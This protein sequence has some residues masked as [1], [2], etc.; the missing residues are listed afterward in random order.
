MKEIVWAVL[1]IGSILGF[2]SF[3]RL[4]KLE[5]MVEM[6][7]VKFARLDNEMA[8]FS[9]DAGVS[10]PSIQPRSTASII[11]R[12]AGDDEQHDDNEEEPEENSEQEPD[13]DTNE[14]NSPDDDDPQDKNDNK[15]SP[16]LI[17][18]Q[19]VHGASKKSSSP[20]RNF[21]ETIGSMWAVW[22]GGLALALGAV[23]LV[24]Y[25]IDRGLLSPAVR[26]FFGIIFSG[27]L[28][29][30]GEWS[31]R[32]DQT[33][34]FA[35]FE[36]ANIPSILTAAGTM[37]LFA[38]IYAAYQLYGMLSDIAAFVALG[39]VAV[40]TTAAAL[41]HG[42]LL[43]ALGLLASYLAPFLV[44]SKDPSIVGL[45]MYVIVVSMAGFTVAR[46]RLWK[47]LAIACAAGLIGYGLILLGMADRID[48]IT[49]A[50][51]VLIS[52]TIVAYVFVVSLYQRNL[53]ELTSMDKTACG[54]LGT[55]LI[56]LLGTIL[57]RS[58]D[59]VSEILLAVTIIGPFLLA[60]AYSA[61]RAVIYVAMATV[62]LGYLGW[63]IPLGNFYDHN[64]NNVD[65]FLRTDFKAIASISMFS[66]VGVVLAALAGGIG[67]IGVQRSVSR[68]ALA[69][70][71]AFL[72]IFLATVAYIR[73]ELF[74]S[75]FSF[76]LIFFALFVA[77]FYLSNRIFSSLD[78]KVA[79]RDGA[80]AAYSTASFVSLALAVGMI[81]ERGALTVALAMLVPAIAYSWNRRPLPAL[82]P[83]AVFAAGL[84]IARVA[85][86]PRIVGGDLGT[87]PLF[88]WLTYGYGLPTLGFV[89]SVWLLGD[90]KRDRWIEA[91]EA[92]ALAS[93]VATLG[94]VSLHAIAPHEV[95]TA[96][97]SLVEVALIAIIGGGAALGLLRITR[98][99][100]SRVLSHGATAL[101]YAGMASA[102]IGLLFIQ[103]PWTTRDKF[104]FWAVFTSFLFAYVFP[105]VIYLTLGRFSLGK[106]PR[107]YS[108]SA[109]ALG[110][111]LL[112]T[113]VNISI[114]H[115][116][117]KSIYRTT[118]AE[119]YMYSIVWLAIG[120]GI[121]ALGIRRRTKML[122]LVALG[123]LVLVVAKVFVIDMSELRGILRAVSFIGL[124]LTL[125][126]IGL[127]YQRVISK[128]DD[129]VDERDEDDEPES[130][131]KPVPKSD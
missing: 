30:V 130:D 93:L 48:R 46:M 51:Y 115:L 116:F 100:A 44:S 109:M 86:D 70:G 67:I 8:T 111:L 77:Y 108:Y 104:G 106:R 121:M 127:V 20:R 63:S 23:F 88:N 113:W 22:V 119:L 17:A 98:T 47:W 122:R 71:G 128:M 72:P 97:D 103:N 57:L 74:S 49:V 118:D 56:V 37:G 83:L 38:T 11:P 35:G 29:G 12:T 58:S 50:N 64:W 95:F 32:R 85:W 14:I 6:M 126:G 33:F 80:S 94:L 112:A 7:R 2:V 131:S 13:T 84:W 68:A 79:G 31:R 15:P 110:G 76:A 124:G 117:G 28:V 42:P 81:L 55:L 62:S 54:L 75:S 123:I 36:R 89:A 96:I 91:L 107:L 25:S 39:L 26:I 61:S 129:P 105:G 66:T 19:S 5:K 60:Y 3:F 41:L 125:M 21:E 92:I 52:W 114:Q 120:I 4:R 59:F 24:K 73:I 82:R 27:A 10:Q 45:A 40:A 101:G 1:S 90:G 34:S 9:G 87:L 53:V 102:A 65:E 18:A 69:I 78:A 43:A 16:G 99:H